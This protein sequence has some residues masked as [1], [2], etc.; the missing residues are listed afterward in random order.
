MRHT[1][2]LAFLLLALV[3]SGCDGFTDLA[4]ISQR[5]VQ[6][7]YDQARDF[8]VALNGAY[9]ALQSDGTFGRNYWLLFEMR[10][11]N[12]DPG[13]DVTGLARALAVINNFEESTTSEDVLN[14]W[15]A[16]YQG[17]ERANV[18]LDQL[19]A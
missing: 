1:R 14:A 13:P 6:E 10:S 19:D 3:W 18:L 9:S 11:D 16:S 2:I 17:I 7:Y 4:P 8:E 15:S 5:N 12:T